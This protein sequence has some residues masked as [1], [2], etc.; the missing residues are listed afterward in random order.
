[1]SIAVYN[2]SEED[3]KKSVGYL[4]EILN[5]MKSRGIN[6]LRIEL[7]QD[8]LFSLKSPARGISRF[9]YPV[10]LRVVNNCIPEFIEECLPI[11]PKTI[12]IF[13]DKRRKL[14]E[15]KILT[16]TEEYTIFVPSSLIEEGEYLEVPDND[17][18]FSVYYK[19]CANLIQ[20][21]Q[22]MRKSIL[23]DAT[24]NGIYIFRH[25][26]EDIG[27]VRSNEFGENFKSDNPIY[28]AFNKDLP[29]I[30]KLNNNIVLLQILTGSGI[31]SKLKFHYMNGGDLIQFC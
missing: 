11:I 27:F 9:I 14:Q 4:Q 28:N 30:V 20:C 8:G 12:D 29:H 10:L 25:T 17:E 7:E 15:N 6:S 1:M 5:A 23:I 21:S 19:A 13:L 24:K 22:G 2:R 3:A 18:L 26:F 16:R 31:I